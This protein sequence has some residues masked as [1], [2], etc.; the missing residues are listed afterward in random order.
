M[1]RP[2]LYC[3]LFWLFFSVL[4][5]REAYR[6]KLGV[7]TKPGPGFF[8]FSLG[9]VMGIL[10]LIVLIQSMGKRREERERTGPKAPF[11]WWNIVIILIA[12]VA[13]AFFL[14]TMGFLISTFLLITL[15]LKV[16]EPQPWRTALLGGL[17]TAIAS[18]LVFNVLLRAQIPTG[19]LGF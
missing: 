8:P 14:E 17:I 11:R 12:L 10:A 7:L 2:G 5:C 1:K 19:F 3:S 16:V 4:I 18:T 15:L 6:L 13:Y 9:F